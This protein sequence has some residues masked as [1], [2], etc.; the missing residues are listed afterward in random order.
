MSLKFAANLSF[1]YQDIPFLDRITAA[2]KDGFEGVECMYPYAVPAEEIKQRLVDNNIEQA[3]FNAPPGDWDGGERGIASLP[4]RE[5]EF[6]EAITLAI[7]YAHVLGNRRL[8]VM[9]GLLP[10]NAN[11]AEYLDRYV[12]NVAWA[13]EQARSIDLTIVLEPINQRAMPGYLL[14][15]QRD[16]LDVIRATGADNVKVQFDCYHTQI[17]EGDI[18]TKLRDQFDQI[19]HIQIASVPNRHEPDGE[20]LNYPFIFRTLEQLGYQGWIGCEYKPRA[21]TSA[22]LQWLQAYRAHAKTGS[23][24]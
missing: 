12:R 6:K 2:A 4:G 10:E 11:R 21:D 18:V 8:H 9:A 24:R 20:E 15:Y 23:L 13:A 1:L 17:M 3:L 19:D 16:A 7:E 22:G 14:S 5:A